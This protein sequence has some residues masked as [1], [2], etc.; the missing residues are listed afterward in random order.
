MKST[1]TGLIVAGLGTL[2]TT[3]GATMMRKNRMGPAMVGFGLAHVVL[4]LAD[5]MRPSVRH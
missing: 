2:V 1:N 3:A 4:G 5:R